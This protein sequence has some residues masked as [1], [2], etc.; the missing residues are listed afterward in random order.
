MQSNPPDDQL[1]RSYLLG[2]LSEEEAERIEPRLLEDDDL[3]LLCE[4]IEADLLAALDRGE[5]TPTEK[6]AVLKRLAAS[7]QGRQRL[8]LARFLN[9]AAD[10]PPAIEPRAVPWVFIHR[11]FGSPSPWMRWAT[12]AAAVILVVTVAW[13]TIEPRQKRGSAWHLAHR[14]STPAPE[15]PSAPA[16]GAPATK[17]S[18]TQED[19][20]SRKEDRIPPPQVNPSAPVKAVLALSLIRL[21]GAETLEKLTI[22][23]GTDLVEIQIDLEGLEDVESFH[24]A[25]R[26]KVEEKTVWEMGG[27][28]PQRLDEGTVLVLEIPAGRLPS[29]RYEVAVTAGTEELT[30]D[31]EVVREN[32]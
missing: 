2:E 31:F 8:A 13:L 23:A 30:Q 29:G 19:H 4:A 12:A 10:R 24:V 22:P 20:I 15:K 11:D 32:R 5:L 21:R 9:T 14:I 17:G 27:F 18:P 1:L 26:S 6:E 25:V 28:K 7:A 16:T 3:F